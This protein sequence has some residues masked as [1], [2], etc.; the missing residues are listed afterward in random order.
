MTTTVTVEAHCD[1][2]TTKVKIQTNDKTNSQPDVF[3]EDGDSY[4]AVV[5]DDRALTISEV[6]LT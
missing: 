4:Q 6:P 1:P 3:I 5:Y 2:A